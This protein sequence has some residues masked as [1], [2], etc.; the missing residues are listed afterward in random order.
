MLL[1][2]AHSGEC[3]KQLQALLADGPLW[4]DRPSMKS[5]MRQIALYVTSAQL[6]MSNS[7]ARDS[8]ILRAGARGSRLHRVAIEQHPQLVPVC[9]IGSVPRDSSRHCRDAT[10]VID[11]YGSVLD[12]SL[13]ESLLF[14][15]EHAVQEGTIGM[16]ILEQNN[17]W[18]IE[19][20]SRVVDVK[21]KRRAS[22]IGLRT[23][24]NL[25]CRVRWF[26]GLC[27]CAEL[28]GHPDLLLK[29]RRL[30]TQPGCHGGVVG[31]ELDA[32]AVLERV[33]EECDDQGMLDRSV[34]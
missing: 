21:A 4:L 23:A 32:M 7:I 8:E 9:R 13:Q 11:A 29:A 6:A 25:H 19:E 1:V 18:A 10:A 14:F 34:K 17:E 12:A 22:K 26:Q 33:A 20:S 15:R 2:F 5:L 24:D 16:V 27:L 3:T 30:R 31:V 28:E